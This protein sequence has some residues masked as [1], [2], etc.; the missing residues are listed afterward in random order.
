[1]LGRRGGVD[2]L[3]PHPKVSLVHARLEREGTTY[4]LIDEGSRHGTTLNGVRLRPFARAPVKAGDRIGIADFVIEIGVYLTELD[5]PGDNSRLIARRM[6]R[7]VL[8]RLGPD[9]AQPR[10]EAPEGGAAL[11]LPDLGRTYILGHA[12]D[13]TLALDAIDMWREHVALLRD[14]GGVTLRPLGPV[15]S[16]R[17]DGA[18]IDAPVL[19]HDGNELRLGDRGLRYVDP[20]E[21]YLRRLEAQPE[22]IVAASAPAARR[23]PR[24]AEIALVLI[25]IAAIALGGAGL[26]WVARW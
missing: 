11:L 10:L 5:G 3:L 23:T 18:R 8:E 24:R 15:T 21:A 16:L 7:D 12:A 17:V 6:V 1:V 14:E 25:G 19:L 20:S 26:V 22:P 13:G 2:V 9:E 4:S